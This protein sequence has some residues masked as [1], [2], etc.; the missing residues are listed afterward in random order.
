MLGLG[1]GRSGAFCLP[2][3]ATSSTTAALRM[4]L[5]MAMR[6]LAGGGGNGVERRKYKGSE[7]GSSVVGRNPQGKG[8]LIASL[9]RDN[10]GIHV[11]A[12][13]GKA[14][15]QLLIVVR[16]HRLHRSLC[17]RRRL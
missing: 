10:D 1:S 9:F 13:G 2:A 5:G 16:A 15:V 7:M 4:R 11:S 6:L 14:G 17:L 8:Q 3:Q 12:G